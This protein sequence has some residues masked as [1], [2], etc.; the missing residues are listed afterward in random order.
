MAVDVYNVTC[1]FDDAFI[2]GYNTDPLTASSPTWQYVD[3]HMAVTFNS[4]VEVVTGSLAWM[5]TP[6]TE[7]SG[8]S[9]LQF[10]Y[11]V[12]DGDE[13]TASNTKIEVYLNASFPFMGKRLW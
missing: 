1:A 3:G 6:T 7:H 11:Y 10:D 4:S 2:C 12:D 8:S 13:D 5:S 9:C